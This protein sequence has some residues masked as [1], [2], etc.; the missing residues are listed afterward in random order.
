MTQSLIQL[1]PPTAR[2][3]PADDRS[4]LPERLID[5]YG[6]VVRNIRLSITDR[7][8]FRCVYCMPEEMEFFPRQEILSYE[9]LVR[10]AGI[11]ARM[12][13]EKVRLTGG[14]PL[15]RREVP[16]LVRALRDLPG[17]RD[18]S[19]TTNGARLTE[20]AHELYDAGLR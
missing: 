5:T 1:A 4:R 15:V 6:R 18:L 17:L 19:L 3:L 11:C 10:L 14:E 9:E 16:T 13:V 12:G 20:L 2:N 7:C 8:N